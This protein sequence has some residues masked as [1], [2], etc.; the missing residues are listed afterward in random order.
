MPTKRPDYRADRDHLAFLTKLKDHLP[1]IEDFEQN[2]EKQL[3]TKFNITIFT[4]EYLDN[5]IS[6]LLSSTSDKDSKLLVRTR[7]ESVEEHLLAFNS[8][9]SLVKT[10]PSCTN[11]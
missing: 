11:I 8:I 2:I 3:S 9:P 4:E 5:I 7:I 6:S 10:G 1:S